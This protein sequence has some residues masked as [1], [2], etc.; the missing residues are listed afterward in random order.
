MTSFSQVNFFH[1]SKKASKQ[2]INMN[3]LALMVFL[4]LFLASTLVHANHLIAQATNVEASECYI[5]H[6]GL[7]TPSDL[8]TIQFLL[9]V[10]Y[11]LKSDEIVSALFKVTYF[12]YPQLRAP[13]ASQ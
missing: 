12:V 2:T 10:G 5:C 8:P 9:T 6:Q 13:P 3:A 1:V 4:L 7:D 11:P